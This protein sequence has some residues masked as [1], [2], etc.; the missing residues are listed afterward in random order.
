MGSF[1]NDLE[2]LILDHVMGVSA[3]TSP[4]TVYIGL[5]TSTCDDTSASLTEPSGNGYARKAISFGA[6]SSRAITQDAQV[7]FDEATGAWGTV[8][9]WFICDHAT[10]TNWGTDVEYLAYGTLSTS[11]SIV[12]GNTPSIASG[13]VVISVTSG[14]CSN[15]LANAMLDHTF[16]NTAYTQPT[17]YIAL[18]ETTE[19]VDADTGATI[20]ELDM[21]GYA[22]EAHANWSASS[23]GATSNTVSAID[24]GTLTGTSETVTAAAV[25]D[26]TTTGAGNVLFYDNSLAQVI[27][28]GDSVQFPIGDFDIS[29]A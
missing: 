12:S 7:D 29:V 19:I 20:D 14:G 23:G 6:A 10:N 21:T 5:S 22:R 24:F 8:T 25:T 15:Y 13:Q 2:D 3:F 4:T 18:V 17:I 28:D 11:R 26:N 27:G 16:D 1:S 9:D